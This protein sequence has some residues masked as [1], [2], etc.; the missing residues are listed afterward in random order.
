M[1]LA[2]V[3]DGELCVGLEFENGTGRMCGRPDDLEAL[4]LGDV[5]PTADAADEYLI[6]IGRGSAQ[7]FEIVTVDGVRH[8]A[9]AVHASEIPGVAF[10]VAR[11]PGPLSAVSG[12]G[13]EGQLRFV[14]SRRTLSLNDE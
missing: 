14:A 11:D 12:L 9:E 10:F 8:E 7:S 2:S 5:R 4:S 6:G 13:P 1:L 3:E